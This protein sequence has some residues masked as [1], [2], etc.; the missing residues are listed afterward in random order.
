MSERLKENCPELFFYGCLF[1]GCLLFAGFK[2]S[3]L[4][5]L[6]LGF[7][8]GWLRKPIAKILD[9]TSAVSSLVIRSLLS[10]GLFPFAWLAARLLAGKIDL[11]LLGLLLIVGF[12]FSL[13]QKGLQKQMRQRD[14]GETVFALLVIVVLT[15]LPF[16]KIGYPVDGKYAYR[17]Y[18][19]SDYLKHF[20]VIEALN[21]GSLPPDNLYFKG[22]TLHYYWLP[23][24]VP[25]VLSRLAGSTAK[26]LF[27]FSFTVNF[28]FILMLLKLAGLIVPRRKE[29]PPLAVL[30]VLTPS[31]EGFYL[32]IARAH[33]SLRGYFETGRDYNIDGLTRWL[34]GL[35]QIDTIFRSLLYTPQHLLSLAF[36]VLFL[37]LVQMEKER[38]LVLSLC[39]ALS[40]SASF[41][42][43]GIFLLS[44]CLYWLGREVTRFVRKKQ[45]PM[46][47]G[48]G[49]LQYFVPAVIVLGLS[50]A[51]KMVTFSGGGVFFKVLAPG[52]MIILLGLNM[53]FLIV[54]GIAGLLLTRFPGRPLYSIMLIV[55]LI[56]I[57]FVRIEN[58]ES[59]ISL[60]AG[61]VTILL[62]ALSLGHLREHRLAKKFFVPLVCL[63]ILPGLLTLVLDIRNS[64]DIRNRRF[65]STVSFEEMRMME[66]IRN[67]IAADR[68]VQ[69]YPPARTWNLSAIPAFSGHQ[70]LV[71]DK[72]HGQIFQ[73]GAEAY[74]KRIEALGR[75]MAALPASQEELRGMGVDYLFWGEDEARHFKYTPDLPVAW[76]I[77]R[78]VLFSLSPAKTGMP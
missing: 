53:G 77:G 76:R 3:A 45:S 37:Y 71:G 23:Y 72:M 27:A 10:L 65:T 74:S 24:A 7:A 31:L 69:N 48:K 2:T 20:S 56:L 4:M 54:G 58:F 64:A 19:S 35:P 40:L 61:L 51:L 66:W 33:F 5:V 9:R 30:L 6:L 55:S 44:W 14:Y 29:L 12:I 17:A 41:F 16:S 73:V 22:E 50:L 38:P 62:L 68:T 8:N 26:A 39:L 1:L 75:A 43:G 46:A 11:W 42:V 57:L 25:S 18:F 28:L 78:T 59:D 63:V 34:W 13:R 36:L 52:Q 47:F 70:M 15:W 67:H 32:W 60:K 49:L 21:K